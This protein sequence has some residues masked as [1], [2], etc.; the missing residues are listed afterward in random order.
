MNS[1]LITRL[2]KVP[3]LVRPN[4]ENLPLS[5]ENAY[6]DPRLLH[7][8]AEPGAVFADRLGVEV[9]VGAETG[10]IP[11]AAA[12][13]LAA[14]LPFAFVRKP[15]YVGHEDH[16]DH[17]PMV[18]GA[19]VAGRHVLLVDDAMSQGTASLEGFA[20]ELEQEGAIVTAAFTVVDMREVA[21]PVVP[22]AR[23][24]PI[25]SIATYPQVLSTA[26]HS[27]AA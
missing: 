14:D 5:V 7:D 3:G 2:A 10:G 22:T 12:V 6:G 20:A 27:L 4:L 26:T 17:E 19:S 11:L 15:G 13:A 18:R 16:E 8:L 23:R 9:I 21:G 25:E 24:L 1:D